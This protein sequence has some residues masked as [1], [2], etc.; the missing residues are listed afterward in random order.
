MERFFLTLKK[1][2]VKWMAQANSH[3]WKDQLQ[4][5]TSNYNNTRHSSTKKI[6]NLVT[7]KDEVEIWQNLYER[8]PRDKPKTKPRRNKP[9]R[10]KLQ[11]TVK[12]T[13]VK[14]TFSRGFD[15]TFAMPHYIIYERFRT[16][17]LAQYRIKTINNKKV[18]G[19]FHDEE[20]QRVRVKADQVYIIDKVLKTRGSGSK[21]ESLVSWVGFSDKIYN[22]WVK[23]SSIINYSKPKK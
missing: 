16:E 7:E 3:S 6:P 10:F 1:M 13:T 23:S 20:L 4:N 5:F 17:G 12:V 19:A 15:E 21:E 11:D 2:V 22:T 9:Y 18:P 8:V 14:G